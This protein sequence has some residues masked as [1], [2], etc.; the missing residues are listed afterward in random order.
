M[1][2]KILPMDESSTT[3]K[4]H[5]RILNWPEYSQALEHRSNITFS[6][7]E[8]VIKDWYSLAS[9]TPTRPLP[10]LFESCRDRC[11]KCVRVKALNFFTLTH[12]LC[13]TK[14][15]I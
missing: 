10:G 15:L 12:L 11:K 14:N 8:Q 3:D 1:S 7:G 13:K 2:S 4:Q 9:I 6:F 5:Y